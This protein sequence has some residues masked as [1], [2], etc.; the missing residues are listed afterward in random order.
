MASSSRPCVDPHF[1]TAAPARPAPGGDQ[2]GEC[3]GFSS[4]YFFAIGPSAGNAGAS[5]GVSC[6]DHKCE[7]TAVG[8]A[9]LGHSC[10]RVGQKAGQRALR[11]LPWPLTPAC[12]EVGA[13][14]ATGSAWPWQLEGEAVVHGCARGEEVSGCG[15]L[16]P[17]GP[18]WVLRRLKANWETV[19]GRFPRL[20]TRWSSRLRGEARS[21]FFSTGSRVDS[22]TR[23]L[24]PWR[25]W[26]ESLYLPAEPV[27]L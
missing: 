5:G 10:A 21:R 19:S 27:A 8:Q 23:M 24:G 9:S 18:A 6:G 14:G 16:D 15:S 4:F 1:V 17:L 12:A 26:G 13:P 3:C 2:T 7:L 22:A 11:L 25:V 20:R